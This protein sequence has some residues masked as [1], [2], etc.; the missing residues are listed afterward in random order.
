MPHSRVNIVIIPAI[1]HGVPLFSHAS[2]S[3]EI[4]PLP[5]CRAPISA[6]AEPAVPGTA[7]SAAAVAEAAIMPFIEKKTKIQAAIASI[8]L[9]KIAN[10]MHMSNAIIEAIAAA[11]LSI[12]SRGNR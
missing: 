6:E 11:V 4:M 3:D 1:G 8:F 9:G 7:S 12:C 2:I 10:D 5:Y